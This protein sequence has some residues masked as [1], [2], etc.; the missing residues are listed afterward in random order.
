[1]IHPN[2]GAAAA[3]ATG[4][5]NA[6]AVIGAFNQAILHRDIGLRRRCVSQHKRKKEQQDC[7]LTGSSVAPLGHQK[8]E[9]Q[10]REITTATQDSSEHTEKFTESGTKQ[11]S[12][13]LLAL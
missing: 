11:F 6:I 7:Q 8:I 2:D 10:E 9:C 12:S 5:E 1:M 3:T 13:Q 4:R